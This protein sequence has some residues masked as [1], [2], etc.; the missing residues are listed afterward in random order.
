M[1]LEVWLPS[2]KPSLNLTRFW[3]RIE[4]RTFERIS[5]SINEGSEQAFRCHETSSFAQ[6]GPDLPHPQTRPNNIPPTSLS[7]LYMS[8]WKVALP[9]AP[10]QTVK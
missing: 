4:D 2:A 6:F 5:A 8:L 10:T 1:H 7:R 3:P 9:L